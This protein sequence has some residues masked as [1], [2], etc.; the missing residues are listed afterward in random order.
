MMMIDYTS[1]GPYVESMLELGRLCGVV[2]ASRG[3][4]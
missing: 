1:T 4:F 3:V 2:V